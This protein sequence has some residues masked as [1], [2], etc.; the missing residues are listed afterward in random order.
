MQFWQF[1]RLTYGDPG[2]GQPLPGSYDYVL[3]ALSLTVACLAGFAAFAVLD[4]L[5]TSKTPLMRRVWLTAG[6]G[7]MGGGIWAMH[8]TGMLAFSMPSGVG[9]D[10]LITTVSVIPAMLGSGCALHCMARPSLSWKRLQGGALLMAVGIGTMHYVG[11]EAMR[12]SAIL[13]Y[14]VVLFA[15]SI[16]VAHVLASV[17]VSLR[18]VFS[19]EGGWKR[20]GAAAAMGLAVTGMHYTAMA[21]SRFYPSTTPE[22]PS[23]EVLAPW[24]MSATIFVIALFIT[25]CAVIASHITQEFEHA[26][27]MLRGTEARERSV[28]DAMVDSVILTD[29][30]AVIEAA[31]PATERIFGYGAEELPGQ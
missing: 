8:F 4:R 17:A 21:A 20:F 26:R 30:N 15:L 2:L 5:R 10:L 12:M 3:V 23:G 24:A 18:F 31:N 13:R 29:E 27:A 14:D 28:L 1:W 16:L 19:T 25:A 22:T 7:T 9:Y 6:M 11:M